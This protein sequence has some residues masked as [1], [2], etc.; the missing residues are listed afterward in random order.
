MVGRV[1]KAD[2]RRDLNFLSRPDYSPASG[3]YSEIRVRAIVVFATGPYHACVTRRNKFVY[4][5]GPTSNEY[6]CDGF[7]RR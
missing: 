6:R 4:E 2:Y 5:R 3:I 1:V 7:G